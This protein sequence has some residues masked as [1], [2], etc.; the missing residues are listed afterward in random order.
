MSPTVSVLGEFD[1]ITRFTKVAR[2]SLRFPWQP[3][4]VNIDLGQQ[5]GI[6]KVKRLTSLTNVCSD[7]KREEVVKY[8]TTVTA[9]ILGWF[10]NRAGTSVDDG[11]CKSNN[12]LDQLQSGKLGTESSI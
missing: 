4:Y 11:A 6:F 8:L 7:R 10:S 3:G 1:C 9:D 12:W 5:Y 2:R